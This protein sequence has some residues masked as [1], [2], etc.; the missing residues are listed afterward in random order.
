M[1]TQ[2]NNITK[3]MLMEYIHYDHLTGIFTKIKKHSRSDVIGGECGY[4]HTYGY[5]VISFMDVKYAAHRLAWFYVHGVWP[6]DEI[7]HIN[8][9]R[10]DNR[11]AN[12][13]ECS[14]QQNMMNR[15]HN[16]TTKSGF[17]GARLTPSGYYHAKIIVNKVPIHLGSFKTAEEASSAYKEAAKEMHREFMVDEKDTRP[18]YPDSPYF[19]QTKLYALPNEEV[20]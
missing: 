11:I 13:R 8:G 16:R 15:R 17:K 7:D 4:V 5:R 18:V 14:R 3:E 6:K 2:R 12:L 1:K 19:E 10:H 20:K 9:I